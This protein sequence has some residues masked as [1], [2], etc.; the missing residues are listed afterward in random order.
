MTKETKLKAVLSDALE[1]NQYKELNHDIVLRNDTSGV[2]YFEYKFIKINELRD[3]SICISLP[4]NVCQKGHNLS[5]VI[6]DTRPV[7]K[8]TKFPPPDTKGSITIIGKVIELYPNGDDRVLVEIKFTQFKPNEWL[9][10]VES[11]TGQQNN[12]SSLIEEVKK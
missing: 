8:I 6:Y 4:K 1:E 5:L 10:V 3:D 12:I 9:K 11:Y 7:K 2:S